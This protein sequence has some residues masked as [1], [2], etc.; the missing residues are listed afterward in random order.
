MNELLDLMPT[1]YEMDNAIW[2]EAKT[3]KARN[4]L[5]ELTEVMTWGAS[6]PVGPHLWQVIARQER[7]GFS[8]DSGPWLLAQP[9]A[10]P[11]IAE[12]FQRWVHASRDPDFA[13]HEV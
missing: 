12:R 6:V 4:R 13:V 9:I 8:A 11:H 7:I 10:G 1:E 3:R 5:N 2:L